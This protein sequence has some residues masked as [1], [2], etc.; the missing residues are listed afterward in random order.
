MVKPLYLSKEIK[1]AI[2]KKGNPWSF[3]NKKIC[4][5]SVASLTKS[6]S[7]QRFIISII[8]ASLANNN[9]NLSPYT[10]SKLAFLT[11]LS[12][13]CTA[14]ILTTEILID[15]NYFI[16]IALILDY[17]IR[18]NIASEKLFYFILF[19]FLSNYVIRVF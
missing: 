18:K 13:I 14:R 5:V 2:K 16:L 15:P 10:M 19:S 1:I 12:P 17:F 9:C 7:V 4:I 6:A 3:L 11:S 8:Y